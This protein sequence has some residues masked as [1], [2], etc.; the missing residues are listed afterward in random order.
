M[1]DSI[2][3]LGATVSINVRAGGVLAGADRTAAMETLDRVSARAKIHSST[4]PT[5]EWEGNQKINLRPV[6]KRRAEVWV[7]VIRPALATGIPKPVVAFTPENTALW[8]GI[9]KFG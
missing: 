8:L 6:C 4:P 9:E 2:P 1:A 7:A 3:S 5:M